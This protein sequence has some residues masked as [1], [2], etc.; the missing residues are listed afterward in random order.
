MELQTFQ[1]DAAI[2]DFSHAAQIAPSP[3]A[4][5][6]LGR[7]L[8]GKGDYAR[9]ADAYTAALRLAPGLTDAR[10]RLDAIREKTAR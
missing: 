1:S 8:E 7:A 3:Q 4:C 5:F 10:S 9:A 2:F 6:W